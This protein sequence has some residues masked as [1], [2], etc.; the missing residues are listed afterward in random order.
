MSCTSPSGTSRSPAMD[1]L[2]WKGM[3]ART[4]SGTSTVST[5]AATGSGSTAVETCSKVAP[6]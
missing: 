6:W 4:S 5:G 3:S 1:A 2:T